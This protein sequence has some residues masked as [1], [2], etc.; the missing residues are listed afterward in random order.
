[1][2]KSI[3]PLRTVMQIKKPS[4]SSGVSRTSSF[5]GVLPTEIRRDMIIKYRGESARSHRCDEGVKLVEQVCYSL[6][7]NR[8][9][10]LIR[11]PRNSAEDCRDYQLFRRWGYYPVFSVNRLLADH[12]LV[13]EHPS[14]C[15]LIEKQTPI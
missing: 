14:E 12:D 2:P 5:T 4:V 10:Y 9:Q 7:I 6:V 11:I 3:R 13:V 1:M 8:Y 15:Q